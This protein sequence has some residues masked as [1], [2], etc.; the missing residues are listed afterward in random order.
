ML[1]I[2][3]CKNILNKNNKNYTNEQVKLI[4]DHLFKMALIIDEVKDKDND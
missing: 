3:V 2:E 1:S 4:R